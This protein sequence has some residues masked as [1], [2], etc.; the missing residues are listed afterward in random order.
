MLRN[1]LAAAGIAGQEDVLAHV[2][3]LGANM[4]L[5][6]DVLHNR[7]SFRQNR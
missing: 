5:H 3:L 6:A 4:K 1:G 2:A 7:S